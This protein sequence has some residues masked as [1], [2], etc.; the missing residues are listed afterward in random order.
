M[1]GTEPPELPGE[2]QTFSTLGEKVEIYVPDASLKDYKKGWVNY[3]DNISPM[4]AYK[5]E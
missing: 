4:S 1:D 5:P 3:K 2:E